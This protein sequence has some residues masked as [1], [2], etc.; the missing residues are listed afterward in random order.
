MTESKTTPDYSI[1]IDESGLPNSHDPKQ[2]WFILAG[3][4]LP[5]NS[6]AVANEYFLSCV[7]KYVPEAYFKKDNFEIKAQ[8]ILNP[9]ETKRKLGMD[10]QTRIKLSRELLCVNLFVKD[11]QYYVTALN[12]RELPFPKENFSFPWRQQY[13]SKNSLKPDFLSLAQMVGDFCFRLDHMSSSG[14][15]SK[16]TGTPRRNGCIVVDES[17]LFKKTM[18]RLEGI[19]REKR[20]DKTI[21]MLYHLSISFQLVEDNIFSPFLTEDSKK[22]QLIQI[23]DLIAG[24]VRFKFE[25]CN[26]P[27]LFEKLYM[28]T[29]ISF[30]NNFHFYPSEPEID[31]RFL[32]ASSHRIQLLKKSGVEI[33]QID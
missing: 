11:V 18:N 3:V 26:L 4:S 17:P 19:L 30:Q 32:G 15:F 23:A 22:S 8:E 24:L 28:E 1:F 14:P 6:L 9:Y 33:D 2:S 12:T 16:K 13:L 27:D 20:I 31:L 5:S 25:N 7:K 10:F 21:Q 29:R